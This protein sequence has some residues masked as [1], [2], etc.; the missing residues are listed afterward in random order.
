MQER[1]TSTKDTLRSS[2]SQRRGQ[3][4]K[5]CPFA[6]KFI[7]GSPPIS[8]INKSKLCISYYIP[9]LIIHFETPIWSFK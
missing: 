6:R 4:V 9:G 7:K 1:V 2:S 8:L 3:S 5:S